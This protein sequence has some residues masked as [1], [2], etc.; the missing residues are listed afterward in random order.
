M[1]TPSTPATVFLS[2]SHEDEKPARQII[3][4]LESAGFSVWWDGLLGG[5]ERFSPAIETALESAK[6]V[7]VLWSKTSIVSSW[8]HDEAAR[9]RDRHC[10]VPLS[11]DG[12]EPPLGFRRIPRDR[13]I[14]FQGQ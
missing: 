4:L 12:S 2:Y 7:V 14:A 11:V 6:V 10:L 8:V 9:G 13:R 5:G 1:D 3:H